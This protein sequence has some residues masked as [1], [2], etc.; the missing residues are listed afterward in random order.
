MQFVACKRTCL[1]NSAARCY[2]SALTS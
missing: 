2:Q 1:G